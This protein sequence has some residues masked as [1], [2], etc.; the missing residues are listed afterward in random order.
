MKECKKKQTKH[1]HTHTKCVP[2]FGFYVY[3][4]RCAKSRRTTY[5]HILHRTC[6]FSP[7]H[8]RYRTISFSLVFRLLCSR[9]LSRRFC[10]NYWQNGMSRALNA[11]NAKNTSFIQKSRGTIERKISFVLNNEPKSNAYIRNTQT[12]TTTTTAAAA[13]V[14]VIAVAA[15]RLFK[16]NET[17]SKCFTGLP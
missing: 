3:W 15:I 9:C 2:V 1:T 17:K 6:P 16:I 7:F 12:T 5:A 8:F 14:V 10:T 13:V 4:K 11:L